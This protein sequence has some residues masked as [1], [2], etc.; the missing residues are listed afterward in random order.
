MRK[1]FIAV[2]LFILIP[3][4]TQTTQAQTPVN[5]ATYQAGQMKYL[6][7]TSNFD[8]TMVYFSE[9]FDI[10]HM[11]GQTIYAMYDLVIPSGTAD[12]F[13][14]TLQACFP[15]M[16]NTATTFFTVD[17]MYCVGQTASTPVVRATSTF[18]SFFPLVRVRFEQTGQASRIA[19]AFRFALYSRVEDYVP[20]AQNYGNVR[21]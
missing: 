14:V 5:T 12:T 8:T 17:T 18:F 20:T 3:L 19:S 9:W 21:P 10:T 13:K 11:D 16:E 6:S 2:L 4:L 7:K 15:G 1:I